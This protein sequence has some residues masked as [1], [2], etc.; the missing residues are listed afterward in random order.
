MHL[1]KIVLPLG[2]LTSAM[3]VLPSQGSPVCP[4]KLHITGTTVNVRRLSKTTVARTTGLDH[5]AM[6][7]Q[8]QSGRNVPFK[9]AVSDLFTI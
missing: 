5:G 4:G 6:S 1:L 9:N 3:S 2:N 8:V 7:V